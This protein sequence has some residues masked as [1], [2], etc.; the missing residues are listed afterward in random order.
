MA[1][2][3]AA[4]AATT[5][6]GAGRPPPYAA[7]AAHLSC[8]ATAPALAALHARLHA[9]AAAASH[10]ER[11][12]LRLLA[13]PLSSAPPGGRGLAA[14]G[15]RLASGASGEVLA[16]RAAGA[17]ASDLVLKVVDGGG[18][19]AGGSGGGGHLAHHNH[20]R[21]LA[22][23]VGEA[24]ALAALA[25]RFPTHP[26]WAVR[27]VDA[28]LLPSGAPAL[29]LAPR[30]RTSARAWRAALPPDPRPQAA[31]YLSLWAAV[32]DAVAGLA[33]AGLAHRDI[34][35]DNVLLVPLEGRGGAGG[36]GAPAPPRHRALAPPLPG[37]A[38][39]AAAPPPPP[40]PFAV[41][42]A[43]F[44]SA[45]LRPPPAAGAPPPA[46]PEDV[47]GLGCL[48]WELFAGRA[49]FSPGEAGAA[50]VAGGGAQAT[51]AYAGLVGAGGCGAVFREAAG[52]SIS[53]AE[54]AARRAARRASL[55]AGDEEGGG[56]SGTRPGGPPGDA[57]PASAAAEAAAWP[58]A[59][60]RL[61][62]TCLARSA[63]ARPLPGDLAAA[64]RGAAGC[65]AHARPAV[66]A[67]GGG[68][69]APFVASPRAPSS[70][71]ADALDPAGAGWA[72]AVALACLAPID[73][74]ASVWYAPDPGALAGAGGL[75]GVG[76][77]G[78]GR[79]EVVV[80]VVVAVGA[81]GGAALAAAR[82]AA[83]LARASWVG[84]DAC[85]PP[86]QALAAVAAAV[87]RAG[88]RGRP[89]LVFVPAAAAAR[90][91]AAGAAVLAAHARHHSVG[92]ASIVDAMAVARAAHLGWG[93]PAPWAE[94]VVGRSEE[95]GPK[96]ERER[97]GWRLFAR[98][99]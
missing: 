54:A 65:L 73:A 5:A 40:L 23:A 56:W 36:G 7:L 58:P 9:P 85:G 72:P 12:L 35:A 39:A 92:G 93:L 19:G 31:L 63:D 52:G 68:A 49:L 48:L 28:G 53:A 81:G 26:P 8:L 69:G 84:V 75:G 18:G 2:A 71:D 95:G 22:A 11:R 38:A 98:T 77:R 27:L 21:A 50:A 6:T 70:P 76:G 61:L 60:R 10:A 33:G 4:A 88:G 74:S 43:D 32:A 55:T 97:A 99:A 13:S 1:A 25:A 14:A 3:A 59:V 64:A 80:V 78:G 96:K 90:P 15:P 91:A 20:Q 34:K 46:A 51:G 45:S 41:V 62:A 42:L 82:S 89:L 86:H 67:G 66:D 94:A 87:G 29:L 24:G 57:L 47:F 30:G 16:A 44:G 37:T 17:A 83:A 79:S